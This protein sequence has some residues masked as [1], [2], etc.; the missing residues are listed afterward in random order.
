MDIDNAGTWNREDLRTRNLNF[1]WTMTRSLV[2]GRDKDKLAG[3]MN[4]NGGSIF[5]FSGV[6]MLKG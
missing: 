6:M 5:F 4:L 3:G 1:M 2:G